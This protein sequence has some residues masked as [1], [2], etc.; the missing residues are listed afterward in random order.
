MV[1]SILI[2]RREAKGLVGRY[3]KKPRIGRDGICFF[4]SVTTSV[5]V[6]Y[7]TSEMDNLDHSRL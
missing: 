4:T 3:C 7:L 5:S 2:R 1:Y 6:D